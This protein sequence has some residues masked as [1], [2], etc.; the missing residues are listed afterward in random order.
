M[1]FRVLREFIKLESSAGAVLFATAVLAIILDNS[2]LSHY[3]QALFQMPVSIQFGPLALAKPFLLW[4]NDGFMAIFFLLVGLEIKREM[5]E[6]ELNSFTKAIL[7]ALAAIGGMAVPAL[8][9]V[10]FNWG[11]KVALQGW[12]IPTA[13][14]IA[15]S[16][17]VLAVLGSRVSPGLKI[18]LTAL[19]IFDDIGAIV[20]IA[21]FYTQNI[22]ML[23]LFVALGLL[24]VLLI[25]NR[26]NIT[27]IAAYML[28][29]V[30]L[31]VCT[32][33]SGVHATLAGILIAFAIPLKDQKNPGKS[34]LRELEH[35]LHPWVAF[36]I[37]PLF[38]FAN[39]GVS[40][41]GM[42]VQSL[43]GPIPLGI[44]LGLFLGKQ[45]GICF[46]TFF[47]V[48]SG[49]ARMPKGSSPTGVYGVSLIAGIGF[50]MSLFIG[51]LAFGGAGGAYAAQVRL[52]VIAGSALS[53]VF[54]YLALLM[55]QSRPM[56]SSKSRLQSSVE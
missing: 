10:Y 18:F 37:L 47:G 32:L 6:G 23:L 19:A 43:L 50:T 45:I 29:G 4:I 21:V 53:G 5:F 33:K 42:S 44:A 9:Y 3:Y 14:D 49:V 27:N 26:L 28:V 54:G 15:F 16:L 8:I 7:P 56:L 52:G 22:S 40:F 12:A 39:A 51:S 24:L 1:P 38:A 48:K 20:V 2:P 41:K 25:F 34:P 31:W 13:T 35:K 30:V 36:G 46:A 17:G 55:A 11:D